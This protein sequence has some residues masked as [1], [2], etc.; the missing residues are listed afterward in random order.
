MEEEE[1]RRKRRRRR[2]RKRG[3]GGVGGT[4][5]QRTH[6]QSIAG[7]ILITKYYYTLLPIIIGLPGLKHF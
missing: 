3:E 5:L 7:R 6:T 1:E 2:R 4:A